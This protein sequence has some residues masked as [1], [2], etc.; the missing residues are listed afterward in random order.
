MGS[1]LAVG[2]TPLL[3][4]S[5]AVWLVH[6]WPTPRSPKNRAPGKG[7]L[8][9]MKQETTPGEPAETPLQPYTTW[10]VAPS[11]YATPGPAG[12]P[13]LSFT[14]KTLRNILQTSLGGERLR[15]RFSNVYGAAPLVIDGAH[16]AIAK[17]GSEIDAAS[18][19]ALSVNGA[20]AFA[21]PAGL[22]VW[23]DA[24]TMTVSPNT[25]LAVSV[26]VK[27]EIQARTWHQFGMQ[28]NYIGEGSQLAAGRLEPPARVSAPATTQAYHWLTGVDVYRREATNV[29]VVLG[30][31][32]MDGFGS[33]LD[34]NHRFTNYLAKRVAVGRPGLCVVNAGLSGN[35]LTLDG[36]VGESVQ[37]R[38]ARDVLSQS[39]VS[40]V[41]VHVGINDLAMCK[42]GPTPCPSAERI[43]AALADIVTQ[44]REK[45]VKVILATLLP[46]KGATL[47]GASL[48]SDEG[49]AKRAAVN[50]W[51]KKNAAVHGVVDF[52]A[53]VRDPADARAIEARFDFGDH[54]HCNDFGLEALANAVD[55]SELR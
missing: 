1:V 44:A 16:V 51:I 22:E 4:V 10:A 8:G 35:R 31:S 32:N 25:K 19:E 37:K 12:P 34:A 33:T 3:Y 23:S 50:T 30:D 27:G 43:T 49:E 2:I 39:G 45:N 15:V 55:L 5:Q 18:D 47:F 11:D 41:L 24:V 9:D 42:R 20:H 53:T 6:S 29:V 36:P 46:W 26:F 13:P 54:L 21:V 48:Y 17:T 52:D 14:N 7:T 40:H 28:T 38:F